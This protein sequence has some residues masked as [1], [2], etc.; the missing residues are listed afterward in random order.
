[1]VIFGKDK[2]MK[3]NYV[4]ILIL[5]IGVTALLCGLLPCWAEEKEV[6]KEEENVWQENEPRGRG[7]F[8]RF[9]LTDEAIERMMSRLEK[10]D[11]AKAKELAKLRESNAEK[12]KAEL[13]KV[14]RE[15]FG[16]RW[17]EQRD[18]KAGQ[19]FRPGQ[20]EGGE[21]RGH[22]TAGKRGTGRMMR[23]RHG[24]FLEW[25]K[26]NYP[27]EAK[28]LDE[29]GDEKPKLYEERLRLNL[30]QYRRIFE[31]SKES[32]KLV[33]VLKEDL[34][35][36]K[37]RNK[38]LTR[39]RATKDADKKKEL[40]KELRDVVN[41][42]YD[43]IVRRKQIEYENLLTKLEKLKEQVKKSKTAVERWDDAGFKN[44]SVKARLEELVSKTGKFR[45][46]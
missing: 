36:K 20:A 16:Q 27:E 31:A 34:Q 39:I 11:P 44:E 14:M 38:L 24:E 2:E 32:P 26:K 1:M 7:S 40:M 17:R 8:R 43:L 46:N 30:R 19:K 4:T 21:H 25:L 45:W 15:R 37:D 35:L 12:F 42:R 41:N 33:K 13:R 6:E 18:Q 29:L 5:A 9:E 10:E 28:K 23:E 3:R 22:G